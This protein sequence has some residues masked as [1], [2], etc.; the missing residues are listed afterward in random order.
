VETHI[1]TG[2]QEFTRGYRRKWDIITNRMEVC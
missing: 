1:E 2:T